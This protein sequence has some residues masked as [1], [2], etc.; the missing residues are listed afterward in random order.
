MKQSKKLTPKQER[1]IQLLVDDVKFVEIC[2]ELGIKRVTLWRWRKEPEFA[3]S[4]EEHRERQWFETEQIM[5][6]TAKQAMMLMAMRG[7]EILR[8]RQRKSST[9]DGARLVQQALNM[10]EDTRPRSEAEKLLET[11][12]LSEQAI[13]QGLMAP[14]TTEV[15][16]KHLSAMQAELQAAGISD[17]SQAI[18]DEEGISDADDDDDDDD[19]DDDDTESDDEDRV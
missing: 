7:M 16:M 19:L 13:K 1:A 15:V 12:G 4:L 11:L 6:K 5:A 9:M 14:N 10:L 2:T 17:V 8:D 18:A 3:R